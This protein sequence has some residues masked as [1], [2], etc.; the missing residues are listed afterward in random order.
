MELNPILLL[1][2]GFSIVVTLW[3]TIFV[4]SSRYFHGLIVA[5]LLMLALM[6]FMLIV[7]PDQAGAVCII[8][9]LI[10]LVVPA[11]GRRIVEILASRGRYAQAIRLAKVIRILHPAD[12]YMILPDI[13]QSQAFERQGKLDAVIAIL[14]KYETHPVMALYANT[15]AM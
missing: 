6:G 2:V 5:C 7:Q 8:A 10:F 12:G 13:L 1:I 15:R 9:W 14:K 3:R 4:L 11:Q